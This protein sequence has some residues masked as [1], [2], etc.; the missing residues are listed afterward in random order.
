MYSDKRDEAFKN[1]YRPIFKSVLKENHV[2]AMTMLSWQWGD[3]YIT[4]KATK[5]AEKGKISNIEQVKANLWNAILIHL[6]SI[7]KK[8]PTHIQDIKLKNVEK[9]F[10][11]FAYTDWNAGTPTYVSEH[12]KNRRHREAQIYKGQA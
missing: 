5:L 10:M 4:G 7:Y 12:E 6:T 8:E 1:K 9:G 2:A 11:M 3:W